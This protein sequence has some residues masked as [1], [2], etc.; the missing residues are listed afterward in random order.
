[1]WRL[2]VAARELKRTG[3]LHPARKAPI[4][5]LEGAEVIG[6]KRGHQQE[7]EGAEPALHLPQPGSEWGVLGS[8][9]CPACLLQLVGAEGRAMVHLGALG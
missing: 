4:Q 2:E 5:S 7:S 1:M 3:P 9:R 6:M 8:A